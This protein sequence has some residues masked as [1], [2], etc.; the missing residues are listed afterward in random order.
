MSFC[1]AKAE[2]AAKL[3]AAANANVRARIEFLPVFAVAFPRYRPWPAGCCDRGAM[4]VIISYD[5][6]TTYAVKA[7]QAVRR[8]RG[9]P[10]P[11]GRAAQPDAR[12]H[13]AP[14]CANHEWRACT[15]RAVAD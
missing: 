4:L 9:R 15:G 1:C 6:L 7:G 11:A 2:T 13:R 5:D 12:S 8:Y 14:D 10:R 3:S